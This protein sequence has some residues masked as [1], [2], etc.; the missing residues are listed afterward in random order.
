MKEEV[1]KI[2]VFFLVRF[3]PQVLQL[4][5][6]NLYLEK[7]FLLILVSYAGLQNKHLHCSAVGVKLYKRTISWENIIQVDEYVK[8]VLDI[9]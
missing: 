9:D 8:L 1:L 4:N 6:K 7:D 5:I 3:F 2:Y